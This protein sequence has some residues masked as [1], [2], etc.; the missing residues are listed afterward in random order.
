M[1]K[2]DTTMAI[3]LRKTL[4][5]FLDDESGELEVWLDAENH[6]ELGKLFSPAHWQ[7]AVIYQRYRAGELL[8]END[9]VLDRG[10]KA[11]GIY[12]GRYVIERLP[13]EKIAKL[14][15]KPE[16]K[17]YEG[18]AQ[19]LGEPDFREKFTTS[20]VVEVT[21]KM[22]K[23]WGRLVQYP[24]RMRFTEEAAQKFNQQVLDNKMGVRAADYYLGADGTYEGAVMALPAAEFVIE[25]TDNDHLLWVAGDVLNLVWKVLPDDDFVQELFRKRIYQLYWPKINNLWPIANYGRIQ[26]REAREQQIFDDA[27]GWLFCLEDIGEMN[28]EIGGFLKFLGDFTV[29]AQA[30]GGVPLP[31]RKR[32]FQMMHGKEPAAEIYQRII[33]EFP[34]TEAMGMLA[35]PEN[36]EEARLVVDDILDGKIVIDKLAEFCEQLLL[37]SNPKE[38]GAYILRRLTEDLEALEA[39]FSEWREEEKDDHF[40]LISMVEAACEGATE[41]DELP[42]L[43]KFAKAVGA[44]APEAEMRLAQAIEVARRQV[45]DYQKAQKRLTQM[46]AY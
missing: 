27:L 10:C 7:D 13:R 36:I 37:T 23:D 2:S 38:V 46:I 11:V 42:E 25:H 31:I 30:K 3:G 20:E 35:F 4:R 22:L 15:E 21:P 32:A 5:Q 18:L 45:A 34:S 33:K 29:E 40:V 24:T 41:E 9:G 12:Q 28:P 8:C 6:P 44:L 16:Q 43:E 1:K 19:E 17:L 14:I 39:Q 26:F